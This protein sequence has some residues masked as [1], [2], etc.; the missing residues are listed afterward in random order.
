MLQVVYN[1][2]NLQKE[3]KRKRINNSNQKIN[4]FKVYNMWVR[5]M[6]SDNRAYYKF[7]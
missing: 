5:V 6:L 1:T 7:S 3:K 4:N 2:S